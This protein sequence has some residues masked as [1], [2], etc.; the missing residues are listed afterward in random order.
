MES[1]SQRALEVLGAAPSGLALME[2]S[3]LTGIP[4]STLGDIRDRLLDAGKIEHSGSRYKLVGPPPPA[5]L[6]A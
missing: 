6:A 2:W 3:R 4:K 5:A 1:A